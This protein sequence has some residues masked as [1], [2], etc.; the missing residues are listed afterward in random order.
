MYR[1]GDR[2]YLLSDG[3]KYQFVHGKRLLHM[4]VRDGNQKAQR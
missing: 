2:V 4:A 3:G 1:S